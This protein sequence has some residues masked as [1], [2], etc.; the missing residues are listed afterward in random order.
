MLADTSLVH[1]QAIVAGSLDW[2]G[3]SGVLQ[4]VAY[5]VV[6]AAAAILAY[7]VAWSLTHQ[8]KVSAS[9]DSR[10]GHLELGVN[11]VSDGE[12]PLIDKVRLIESRQ[13]GI[14]DTLDRVCH[15]L[16]IP[17]HRHEAD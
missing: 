5:V 7:G 9:I 14:V 1:S 2:S 3:L 11:G 4:S 16:G 15:H 8:R 6:S 12:P 13:S 10:L 17:E